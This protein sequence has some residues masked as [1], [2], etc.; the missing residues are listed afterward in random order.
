M[1]ILRLRMSFLTAYNFAKRQSLEV[2]YT[3]CSDSGTLEIKARGRYR[4]TVTARL[5]PPVETR[6][7]DVRHVFSDV[8][9]DV[10]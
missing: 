7:R 1:S 6:P 4:Q 2:Q 5:L 9:N 3:L 8:V 10:S